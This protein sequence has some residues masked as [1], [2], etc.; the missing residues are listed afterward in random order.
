MK[1]LKNRVLFVVMIIVLAMEGFGGDAG[2]LIFGR[3]GSSD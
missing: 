2:Y 1:N 3:R